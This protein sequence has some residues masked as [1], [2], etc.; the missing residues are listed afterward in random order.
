MAFGA[1]LACSIQF[2]LFG[3]PRQCSTSG[4]AKCPPMALSASHILTF[5]LRN[6]SRP[7]LLP[8]SRIYHFFWVIAII[9]PTYRISLCTCGNAAEND[10]FGSCFRH[11]FQHTPTRRLAAL[12]FFKA[13][14]EPPP[15]NRYSRFRD[16]LSLTLPT[17]LPLAPYPLRS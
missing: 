3:L 6:V 17:S 13:P 7:C 11:P 2:P 14:R 8:H 10:A 5:L 9:V 4:R 16:P 15:Q 1:W 12:T